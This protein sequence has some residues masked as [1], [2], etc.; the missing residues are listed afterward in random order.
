MKKVD[1]TLA[2]LEMLSV[3][4]LNKIKNS[5]LELIVKKTKLKEKLFERHLIARTDLHPV[6]KV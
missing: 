5:C 4:D 2:M 1:Q 3:E 6:C